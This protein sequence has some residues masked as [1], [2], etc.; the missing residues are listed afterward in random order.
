[1]IIDVLC[2]V[3]P[4]PDAFANAGVAL[5]RLDG[6]LEHF[7]GADPNLSQEQLEARVAAEERAKCPTEVEMLA[8][9]DSADVAKAVLFNETYDVTLGIS[10]STNEALAGFIARH[11][12]RF[13][14]LGGVDPWAE[15]PGEVIEHGVQDLGLQGFLLSPF[16]QNVTP[17]DPI[18]TPIY[19]RCQAL[20]VPVFIHTGI[21]W[22]K[23]VSYDIDHPRYLDAL[24][25][26]FPKLKIV[27][28][29]AGWPWLAEMMIV[30]WRH[31]N[32]FIDISAHRPQHLAMPIGG[33]DSLLHYGNRMLAERVMFGSTWTLI[34]RPIADLIAEVRALP[35]KSAVVDAWL[36]GNAQRLFGL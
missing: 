18:L 2:S 28:M 36:G 13:I 11:P 33:G 34:Q 32:I 7:G 35:L 30:A 12:D 29:H 31:P 19:E 6:Y 17:V 8:M 3:T 21:N 22:R 5:A 16:K 24:A 9:L 23:S 20:G 1:M 25:G 26:A 27:A 10:P 15:G 14:G 4:L